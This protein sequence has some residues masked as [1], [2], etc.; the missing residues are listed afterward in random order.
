MG[1][2]SLSVGGMGSSFTDQG[3]SGFK[4]QFQK[5]INKLE[6]K[7]L[8]K[9]QRDRLH[10]MI[11]TRARQKSIGSEFTYQD[12]KN[13]KMDAYKDFKAGKISEEDLED[14]KRVIDK[15]DE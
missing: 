2:D 5:F 8:S 9:E 4:K 1:N 10:G 14:F 13:L 3:S 15:L 12:K 11:A 7:N 6:F